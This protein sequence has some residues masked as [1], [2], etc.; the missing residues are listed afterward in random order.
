MRNE[1][2]FN[3]RCSLH[4]TTCWLKLHCPGK[5]GATIFSTITLAFLGPIARHE[6]LFHYNEG[7][8]NVPLYFRP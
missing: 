8:K 4:A 7:Y 2:Q 3:V 1:T 5:K 6:S